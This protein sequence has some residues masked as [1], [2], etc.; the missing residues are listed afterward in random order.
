MS[1]LVVKVPQCAAHLSCILAMQGSLRIVI[2]VGKRFLL[3]IYLLADDKPFWCRT[4]VRRLRA[5]QCFRS[6]SRTNEC[7]RLLANIYIYPTDR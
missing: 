7:N 3:L 4:M 5:T 6:S 2:P 1:Y